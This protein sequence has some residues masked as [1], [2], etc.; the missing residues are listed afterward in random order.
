M[1][2]GCTIHASY[3]KKMATAICTAPIKRIASKLIKFC[4][5]SP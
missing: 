1:C 5:V 3:N 2:N 4:P